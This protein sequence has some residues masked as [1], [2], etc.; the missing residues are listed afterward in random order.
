M[1]TALVTGSTAGIGRA[2]ARRLAAEGH[3][4]VLVARDAERL[5]QLADSLR[6][7]HR[8]TVEVLPA[9]LADA[10]QLAAVEKR[11]DDRGNPVDLLVNNAGFGTSGTFWELEPEE[12]TTQVALNVTAVLRLTRAVVPG[13]R[14]RG[15]GEVLNVSSVAAF[16][17]S[18]GSTYAATKAYVLTFS[19]GLAMSL[20][21]AGVRI[22]AVCP[23]F[24][25]TEFH[26]RAGLDMRGL[27]KSMWL[28]TDR[29]VHESLAD[30][31]SGKAVSVPGLRYKALVGA[32]RLVPFSLQRRIVERAAPDRT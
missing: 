24:T 18:S 3:D 14:E 23:G 8:V 31:R 25:R 10:E 12:L 28:T 2:Y 21:P 9:D 5:E 7:R 17:S 16:F 32:G 20:A 13:M 29:V 27:P 19:R 15:R 4:M 30:L 22:A 1:P 26:Q 6:Q 11:L